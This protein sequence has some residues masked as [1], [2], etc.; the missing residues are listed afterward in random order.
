MAEIH[1]DP[2][3]TNLERAYMITGDVPDLKGIYLVNSVIRPDL[4]TIEATTWTRTR[5]Q[6]EGPKVLKDGT[7]SGKIRHTFGR[8]Q[9][10]EIP[11]WLAPL[12]AQVETELLALINP[13]PT[14]VERAA[15]K[16]AG[17]I[18]AASPLSDEKGA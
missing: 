1:L 14:P 11:D 3:H 5:I 12:I 13:K 17:L 7:T 6:I 9:I 15:G 18:A 8:S 16:L 10:A 2:H 4:V